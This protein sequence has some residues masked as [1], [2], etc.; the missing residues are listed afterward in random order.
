MTGF[1]HLHLHTQYSLLDGACRIPD[2]IKKVKELGQRHVAI[3][4]HGAMFGV[5]EFY[6][7]A[8]AAGIKPIIGCEVYVAPRTRF[9]K[10]YELDASPFHLVLLCEN[11]EG[12]KNLLKMVSLGYTEGFYIKPRVD[13]E[14]LRRYC[15]GLIAMSACLAGE[16][17]KLLEARNYEAAKACALEMRDIFGDNNFFLELQDHGLPEQKRVNKETIRISQET[18]IPLVATNDAHYIGRSDARLQDVLLCIQTNKKI[19]DADRMRFETD[20]FYVKSG[21]EMAALFPNTPAA[22]ENTVKIAERCGVDF[23]F[24]GY[25]LPKFPLPKGE[26][27]AGAYLRKLCMEG[28]IRRYGPN[29]GKEYVERLEYELGVISRM[30][31]EDYF[32]IVWDY[33]DFAKRNGIPVGPGRGSGAGSIVAYCL[34]ITNICPIKYKLYFERFLNPER[35]SMPDIDI[36][37]CPKRRE[38][39]V[40]YIV[41]K[42]GQERVVQIITFGTMAARAAVRDTTRALD[43]PYSLGD[44]I[45]KLI[46][47]TLNITISEAL[48]QSPQLKQA[49]ETDDN[50]KKVIDIARGL[51][52]MPRNVSTHAA[53]II[54]TPGEA[55]DYVPLAL[56][57][58]GEGVVTQFHMKTIE[59]IGLVKMDILGLRN[60]TIIDD[61][62][63]QIRKARPDFDIYAVPDDDDGT[64]AMLAEG[65]TLGVFQLES[66]GMTGVVTGLAP[67]SI[68][69]IT[70]IVALY[71]PGPMESIPRFINGKMHPGQVR[72]RHPMLKDILDLTYGCIVYQEQVM[73]IFRKLA[74]YSLGKAD[75]VRRAISK[76][77]FEVLNAE[78][79]NFISGS[80]RNGVSA[81]TANVLFDEILDFANYAF[82]KAHAAAYA[83]VSYQ[84]AYLKANY[85]QEY[86]GALLSSVLDDVGKIAEYSAECKAMGISVLPP[87]VNHS[88]NGFVSEGKN[89]RFG[90]TAVKN[91]GDKFISDLVAEREK[92]G[93]FKSFYDFCTRMSQSDFNRRAA[94]GLIKCGACDCFGL[95]RSQMLEMF[96]SVM[97]SIAAEKSR[98]LEGQMG[99]FGPVDEV[100]VE[101]K[102][103][104][105]PE[106]SRDE[107][108]AMEKEVAG[109]YLTGHP[110]DAY[111]KTMSEA[112][113]VRIREIL[114]DYDYEGDEQSESIATE[115]W[116]GREVIIGG[117][118]TSV[119]TKTTKSGQMMAFAAIEDLSGSIEALVF[120]TVITACGGYIHKDGMI[121]MQ[122]RVSV[123]EGEEPK[124]ICNDA[125]PLTAEAK[126]REVRASLGK[127]PRGRPARSAP[128]YPSY[129]EEARDQPPQAVPEPPTPQPAPPAQRR[130]YIKLTAQN[131][132]HEKRIKGLFEMFPGTMPVVLYYADSGRKLQAPP[133]LWVND[134]PR[135]T[136]EL[137]RLMGKEN[138]KQK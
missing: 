137:C 81:D 21:D 82:N 128:D 129:I 28:L 116:D 79:E 138:V 89:I 69:E 11:M 115:A 32:L 106:F 13:R 100:A 3:T 85:P 65:R 132:R 101:P 80:V 31:Y 118:V 111:V 70:A 16:I 108:L 10:S 117:I 23:E 94:E 59:E 25:V 62:I 44:T 127:N 58:E 4:D 113:A 41:S 5:M 86:M 122:G 30:G 104:D 37:F 26:E 83:V 93:P 43:L 6:K 95:H 7:E 18:G 66:G 120:P 72:Y 126:T 47:K 2:L 64:Y 131:M 34:G 39:V 55:S 114:G 36:D 109:M 60:L 119:K 90:L 19:G 24:K 42:Y 35:I 107:L 1:A 76:K 29:P 45:A 75:L 49:Y 22:L 130:L 125:W 12:Y 68:E 15:G 77:K 78:R 135:L 53:G 40:N 91:V 61:A 105:I 46:P 14:L 102:A 38:E 17:P 9:D 48:E 97:R 88:E 33:V 134:D 96:E 67:H 20:E 52:G 103:P 99:L 133:T 57:K 92:N 87:D 84:T 63:K 56:G 8:R 50:V 71:R 74:G 73:E 124:I 27:S 98:T 112:G 123:R 136:A 110:L 51:E 121:F 54:I